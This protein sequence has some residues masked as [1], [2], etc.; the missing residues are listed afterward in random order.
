MPQVTISYSLFELEVFVFTV[1][2]TCAVNGSVQCE[3]RQRRRGLGPHSPG[4]L[5]QP[6]HVQFHELPQSA[7]S[8]LPVRLGGVHVP[9]RGM[10]GS[11]GDH[12]GK[13]GRLGGG[14]VSGCGQFL[15]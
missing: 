15:H 11:A 2:A 12:I 10:R 13:G 8:L 6:R 1:R 3:V 5:L 9:L 14:V 4:L 7:L